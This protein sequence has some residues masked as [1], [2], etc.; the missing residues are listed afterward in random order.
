MRHLH[1][2]P[3]PDPEPSDFPPGWDEFQAARQRFFAR[4]VSQADLSAR[5]PSTSEPPKGVSAS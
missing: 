5:E 2:V 1:L 4:L 3:D